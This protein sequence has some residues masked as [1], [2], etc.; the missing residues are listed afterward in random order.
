MGIGWI[1]TSNCDV[2]SRNS[3]DL[4]PGQRETLPSTYDTYDTSNGA[5]VLVIHSLHD[6]VSCK[7][8]GALLVLQD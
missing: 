2:A 1:R 6:T 5:G 3:D 7:S 4:D 8:A